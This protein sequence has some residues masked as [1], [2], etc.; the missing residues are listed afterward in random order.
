MINT[1]LTILMLAILVP[2]LTV[3]TVIMWR[4]RHEFDDH[5]LTDELRNVWMEF[6]GRSH[7]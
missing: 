6:I 5:T 3:F 7:G 1:I 2:A 4:R